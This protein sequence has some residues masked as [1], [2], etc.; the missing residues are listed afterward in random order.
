MSDEAHFDRW[1]FDGREAHAVSANT[2]IDWSDYKRMQTAHKVSPSHRVIPEFSSSN[3]MLKA[4]IVE[5][6]RRHQNMHFSPRAS[7]EFKSHLEAIQRVGSYK[8]L[9]AAV[10]YRSWRLRHDCI[11]VA[12]DTGISPTNVRQ[13]LFRMVQTA[14]DLGLPV[15]PDDPRRDLVEEE[16]ER[17]RTYLAG[18]RRQRRMQHRIA[19]GLKKQCRN[20]CHSIADPNACHYCKVRPIDRSRSMRFCTKCADE[21][22]ARTRKARE[23]WSLTN[24]ND[25]YYCGVNPIDRTRSTRLCTACLDAR[26]V[27]SP[28]KAS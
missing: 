23:Q 22:A 14:R 24:P 20:V 2:G 15:Y 6:D 27:K 11:Q 26:S 1:Q 9:L 25:C 7:A 17:W 8:A 13:H 3:D 5:R 12:A 21:G 10:A 19:R 4:V 28:R 16:M 18:R